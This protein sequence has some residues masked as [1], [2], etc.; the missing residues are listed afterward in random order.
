[1]EAIPEALLNISINHL[2]HNLT[3]NEESMH[4]IINR[5]RTNLNEWFEIIIHDYIEEHAIAELVSR[6]YKK[7][8]IYRLAQWFPLHCS[9]LAS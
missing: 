1:L 8:I 4:K 9:I 2:M 5:G 6:N 3:P 7:H